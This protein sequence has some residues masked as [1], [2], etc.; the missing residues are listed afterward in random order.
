LLLQG[1]FVNIIF[2]ERLLTWLPEG[3]LRSFLW[4]L[5]ESQIG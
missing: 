5:P 1:F 3:L 2:D 4:G